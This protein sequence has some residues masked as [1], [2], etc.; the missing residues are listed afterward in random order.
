METT[1][2]KEEDSSV[3]IYMENIL[4]EEARHKHTHAYTDTHRCTHTE[5]EHRRDKYEHM[6]VYKQDSTGKGTDDRDTGNMC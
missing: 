5:K 6:H 3:E 2:L 1:G 4:T